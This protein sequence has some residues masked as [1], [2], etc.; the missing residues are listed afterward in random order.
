MVSRA[1]AVSPVLAFVAAAPAQTFNSFHVAEQLQGVIV[2]PLGPLE[3]RIT[4]SAE[5]P[6]LTMGGSGIVITDLI[7]FWALS[8][9]DDIIGATSDFG[10]WDA[11]GNNASTGGI[12]GW[13]TNPNN[14]LVPGGS[15]TFTFDSLETAGVEFFGFRVR[16]AGALPGGGNVG[17]VF[18]PAPGPAGALLGLAGLLA[19]RRKR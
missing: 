7:G 4:L 17:Y 3:Y 12:L 5:T 16:V 11:N 6:M 9:D 10:V 13:K 8:V 1:L 14:G 2:E 18:V 15:E 19:A